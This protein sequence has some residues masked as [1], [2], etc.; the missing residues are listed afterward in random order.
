MWLAAAAAQDNRC[1]LRQQINASSSISTSAATAA[2]LTAV[3]NSTLDQALS[4]LLML[5]CR[6]GP[7]LRDRDPAAFER[8]RLVLGYYDLP[9]NAHKARPPPPS[10][11]TINNIQSLQFTR[12]VD[13]YYKLALLSYRSKLENLELLQVRA[14]HVLC[15][16]WCYKQGYFKSR[17]VTAAGELGSAAGACWACNNNSWA[18]GEDSWACGK[19]QHL[20]CIA[21]KQRHPTP[22]GV[23]WACAVLVDCIK[24]VD[25]LCVG[26]S[27]QGIHCHRLCGKECTRVYWVTGSQYVMIARQ[28]ATELQL[29]AGHPE[30]WRLRLAVRHVATRVCFACGEVGVRL[31][32]VVNRSTGWC[33]LQE[34]HAYIAHAAMC[35]C[36]N[37]CIRRQSRGRPQHHVSCCCLLPL[38]TLAK[39]RTFLQQLSAPPDFVPANLEAL[40]A[41]TAAPAAAEQ[42]QQQEKDA[43]GEQ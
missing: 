17:C 3:A 7:E 16:A 37:L 22:A 2:N 4:S 42:Q 25:M 35:Y 27:Q 43:K 19:V 1:C 33:L 31:E 23:R 40:S 39:T 9:K 24:K 41:A 10:H 28:C 11:V 6:Y 12:D 34:P 29:Q 13:P 20:A 18:C 38:Q 15:W 8:M 26:V 30:Q 21:S 5:A 36:C 32:P 14:G